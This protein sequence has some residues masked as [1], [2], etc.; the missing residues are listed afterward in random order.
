MDEA[1]N[2]DTI[3]MLDKGDLIAEGSYSDHLEE[4]KTDSLEEAFLKYTKGEKV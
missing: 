4:T 2:C 3:G 1:R